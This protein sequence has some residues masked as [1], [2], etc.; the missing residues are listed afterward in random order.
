M[1]PSA[2]VSW[3]TLI[4]IARV[5]WSCGMLMLLLTP[6]CASRIPRRLLSSTSSEL[7]YAFESAPAG[8]MKYSVFR[9][10]M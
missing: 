2:N 5:V 6:V 1:L 4:W 7:L 9:E 8:V 3:L 10:E